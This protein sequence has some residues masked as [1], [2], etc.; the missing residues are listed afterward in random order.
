[1]KGSRTAVDFLRDILEYSEK[2]MR[3]VAGTPSVESLSQD[4]RTL[5]AVTRA[6]E[7]I[8]EAAKRI[9]Q[10]IRDNYPQIPW[11]G[12]AGMRDKISHDYFGVDVEVVWRT[13]QDEL[14]AL[15]TSISVIL[16]ELSAVE[17]PPSPA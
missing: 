6:L 15:Q 12:M 2:A 14:P 10:A 4:E 13:V 3:F 17:E 11:R 9:P 7:V 5:L 16:H 1:M 8:G